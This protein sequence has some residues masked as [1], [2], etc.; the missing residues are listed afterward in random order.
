VFEFGATNNVFEVDE[1]AGVVAMGS[2]DDDS[3][4]DV[5][6]DSVSRP[7]MHEAM[8]RIKAQNRDELLL[9]QCHHEHTCAV[10]LLKLL[11][12]AHCPD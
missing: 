7:G 6:C 5:F 1:C 2:S 3:R 4:A 10:E 12:K 9:L 8:D 11:E